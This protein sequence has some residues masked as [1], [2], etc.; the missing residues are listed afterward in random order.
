MLLIKVTLRYSYG[1][2]IAM[3]RAMLIGGGGGE[4][5]NGRC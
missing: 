1:M 4:L 3:H 2:A 5:L